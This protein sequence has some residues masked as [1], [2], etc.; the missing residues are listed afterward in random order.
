M[1]FDFFFIIYSSGCVRNGVHHAS[2]TEWTEPNE[3]CKILTCK[4]GVITESKLRC[5]T[6]CANPIPAPPGQCCPI[7]AGCSVNG[8]KVT[9]ERTVTTTEDPCVTCRCNMGRLTCAKKACP[10]LHCPASSLVHEPGECCPICKG[11]FHPQLF[12]IT[13]TNVSMLGSLNTR[14]F[15]VLIH[16]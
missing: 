12:S 3:P 16:S 13:A 10:V 5:Y 6:P 9:A 7:C 15:L 14:M 8:Q 1:S 11:N 2:D 4:A